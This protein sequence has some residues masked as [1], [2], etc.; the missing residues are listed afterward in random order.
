[1]IQI[2]REFSY[3]PRTAVAKFIELCDTC[4]Y[5]LLRHKGT[6]AAEIGESCRYHRHCT[7]KKMH[8]H[9]AME[10]VEETETEMETETNTGAETETDTQML[11]EPQI[12]TCTEETSPMVSSSLLLYGNEAT[13]SLQDVVEGMSWEELMAV[14]EEI[15]TSSQYSHHAV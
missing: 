2:Q 9:V 7:T 3:L 14:Y 15:I 11:L 13:S 6:K 12:V 5:R 8:E 10:V 1:M 4:S